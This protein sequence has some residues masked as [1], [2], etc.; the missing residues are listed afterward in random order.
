MNLKLNFIFRGLKNKN[1]R[2][3]FIGQ[4]I[5]LTGTWMQQVALSWLVY[6]LTNS[7]L[8]LGVVGFSAQ[9]P[10]FLVAPFAGIIADRY[11]RHKALIITQI[12]ALIQAAILAYLVLTNTIQIW[13]IVALSVFLG[14]INAF[15][16]P[17]RQSFTIDM[18]D[19][20]DDLGNAIA[21]NSAMFN[22]ARLIGPSI[23]GILIA[24]FGEG[25]CFLINAVSYI[26][27][28]YSLSLIK[29]N[30]KTN[31]TA[32]TKV[33][34]ELKEGIKYAFNFRPIRLTLSILAMI[35]LMGVSSQVLM[36]IFAKDIFKGGPQ[37]LGMLV[38]MAGVGALI[39]TFY[40]ASQRKLKNIIRIIANTSTIF[41]IGLILFSFSS[42]FWFSNIVILICGFGMMVQMAS[43]NTLLQSIVEDDKRGR[44]MS[45]YTMAFIGTIP[46][47]SLLA[48]GLAHKIGAPFTI[49]I[50]G[51]GCLIS[52][53][54]F[55]RTLPAL[56]KEV[57]PILNKKG[58]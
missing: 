1:Y 27:V 20:K 7:A 29:I 44:V 9:I 8:F 35:S 24:L 40:L 30:H 21:L 49:F 26:A 15:D 19:N 17:I 14:L 56:H 22:S 23:A 25:V 11:S 10:S 55:T 39:G 28:I 31:N 52:A 47:G 12:L 36:P 4:S 2:L 57:L 18:L 34:T 50:T 58:L 46:F 43:C 3:F 48:G 33:F 5:S 32:K 53:Y 38:S 16:A 45:F 6:N 54:F 41:G 13:H 51:L 42:N 37:T